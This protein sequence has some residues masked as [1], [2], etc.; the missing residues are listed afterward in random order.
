MSRP[1]THVSKHSAQNE[2]FG[3]YGVLKGEEQFD[4]ISEIW[5]YEI[6]IPKSRI[7]VQGVLRGHGG[8]K[9][10]ENKRVYRGSIKKRQRK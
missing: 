2:R 3:I 4:D 7:L 6:C 8:Q 9:Y 5:E 1:H 10:C